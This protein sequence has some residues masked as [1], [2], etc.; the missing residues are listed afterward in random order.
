MVVHTKASI[1]SGMEKLLVLSR[2]PPG[3]YHR[4]KRRLSPQLSITTDKEL[5]AIKAGARNCVVHSATLG[6][7]ATTRC[8]GVDAPRCEWYLTVCQNVGDC[9]DKT[10]GTLLQ[11]V[12]S[13]GNEK[14]R[15]TCSVQTAQNS[16][17][18][19][20]ETRLHGPEKKKELSSLRMTVSDTS[21]PAKK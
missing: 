12:T 19:R 8:L 10:I 14:K 11:N 15:A 17:D 3:K 20:D 2:V 5:F 7:R 18:K 1:G 16:L 9:N 13:W 21:L 6:R 4:L